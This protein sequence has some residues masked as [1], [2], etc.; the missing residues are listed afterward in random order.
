MHL[1]GIAGRARVGKDTVAQRLV[2]TH[3]FH[4]YS[5]AAPIKVAC[6]AIFGWGDR[7][8][9]GD[10]KEVVDPEYGVSPRQ[11]M[12]TLGTEWGRNSIN[13]ELWLLRANFQYVRLGELD[14][15]GRFKGMVVSDVRF[16]NEA[17]W[18]R[19]KGG[20]VIHVTRP[21][22]TAVRDHSS[23]SGVEAKDG[24]FAV[25]N[26]AGFAYLYKQ[27]DAIAETLDRTALSKLGVAD[28]I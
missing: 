16:N 22:R 18:I 17:D 12:Q 5:F 9:N 28:V 6:K 2:T 14:Q 27:V 26:S 1:I 20:S 13:P 3:S 7:H 10:L 21:E 11:A 15:P 19:S 4:Q 24:D 23:E 8:V 25:V